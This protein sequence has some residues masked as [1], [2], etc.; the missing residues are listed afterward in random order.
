MSPGSTSNFHPMT[1]EPKFHP[2]IMTIDDRRLIMYDWDPYVWMG[3]GPKNIK[4]SKFKMLKFLVILFWFSKIKRKYRILLQLN[5][6]I[7][8]VDKSMDDVI[9]FLQIN[10]FKCSLREAGRRSFFSRK[11][12]FSEKA[13]FWINGHVNK[14]NILILFKS[15]QC[16]NVT[17]NMKMYPS[18]NMEYFF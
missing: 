3:T 8:W 4:L 9:Y 17:V 2:Q 15:C 6:M 5:E 11:C 13:Y 16:R 18:I 7:I 10:L 12:A 1:Y 14:H